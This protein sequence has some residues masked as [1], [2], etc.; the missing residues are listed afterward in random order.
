MK[1]AAKLRTAPHS[2][3][4][5]HS[6]LKLLNIAVPTMRA[7]TA[8]QPCGLST[9]PCKVLVGLR[10][11]WRNQFASANFPLTLASQIPMM[12]IKGE[13][14]GQCMSPVHEL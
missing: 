9:N 1:A 13:D 5:A 3:G 7:H 14:G 4:P 10:F 12:R 8:V 6:R 2:F 11:L